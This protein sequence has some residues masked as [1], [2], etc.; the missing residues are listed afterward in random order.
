MQASVL[1]T[2]TCRRVLGPLGPRTAR[3]KPSSVSI[4]P[5]GCTLP[6]GREGTWE[7][8]GTHL[9]RTGR[10]LSHGFPTQAPPTPGEEE[11]GIRTYLSC[12]RGRTHSTPGPAPRTRSQLAAVASLSARELCAAEESRGAPSQRPGAVPGRGRME[13]FR[14]RSAACGRAALELERALRSSVARGSGPKLHG[15]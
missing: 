3:Q 1:V 6:T 7:T 13:S 5:P 12:R 11:A 2:R 8:L 10:E 9:R 15:P 14:A 4:S